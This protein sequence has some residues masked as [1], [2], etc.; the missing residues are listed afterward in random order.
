M[1]MPF[2]C[3]LVFP[4]IVSLVP[5]LYERAVSTYNHTDYAPRMR[6]DTTTLSAPRYAHA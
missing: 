3:Q 5:R 2:S 4:R 1:V 6:I